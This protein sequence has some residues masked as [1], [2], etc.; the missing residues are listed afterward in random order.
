MGLIAAL[1]GLSRVYAGVHFPADIVAG[2]AIGV[3][4]SLVSVT[5]LRF[6]EPLTAGILRLAQRVYIA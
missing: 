4:A 3:L 5:L 1:M 2:A 6:A